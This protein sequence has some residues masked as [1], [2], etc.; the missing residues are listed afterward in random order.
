M[1][2]RLALVAAVSTVVLALALSPSHGLTT[3]SRIQPPDRTVNQKA[4][5]TETI[6]GVIAAI[7]A[8]GEVMFDY[9]TN[10]AVA[11]EAAFLTVIGSPVKAGGQQDDKAAATDTERRGS[12]GRQRHN[13]YNVWLT[14][15][16]KICEASKGREVRRSSG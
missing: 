4:A 9:R 3:R 14:P 7:T 1:R 5:E 13:V 10:R 12:S 11:A 16:T 8:E 15:R 6:R 2:D